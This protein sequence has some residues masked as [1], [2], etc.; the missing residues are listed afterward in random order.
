MLSFPPYPL[1]GGS[2]INL[3]YATG[4]KNKTRGHGRRIYSN[5]S[6]FLSVATMQSVIGFNFDLV[7]IGR[8]AA[9]ISIS[10]VKFNRSELASEKTA[11]SLHGMSRLT[12][13]GKRALWPLKEEV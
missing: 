5:R 13:N 10:F 8:F 6:R 1:F 9:N 7:M 3:R 2:E 11:F 12:S 4:W